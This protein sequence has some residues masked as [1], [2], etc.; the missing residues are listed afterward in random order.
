V[1]G[2]LYH[3]LLAKGHGDPMVSL[4]DAFDLVYVEICGARSSSRAVTRFSRLILVGSATRQSRHG[5]RQRD[6][7][8]GHP[9]SRG[10]ARTR[11]TL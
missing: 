8:W 2:V 3:Y 4:H 1:N 5:L 11:N 10:K 9:R 7:G 6:S